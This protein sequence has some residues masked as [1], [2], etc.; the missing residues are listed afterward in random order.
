MTKSSLGRWA[1]IDIETSGIDPSYDT[2][3]DVGFLQFEGTKLVRSYQSLV[4]RE[5]E[6][7]QFIQKLTGISSSILKNAPKWKEV[8][9]EVCELYGH[10]LLAHNSDFEKSFLEK[11]F[12]AIED[13][14]QREIYADSLNFLGLLFPDSESLKLEKFI[15]KWGLADKEIHRGYEDSVDLLKVLIVAK[16]LIEKDKKKKSYLDS[17]ILK[18]QLDEWWYARFF[19]LTDC[20]TLE[21]AET[22]GFDSEEAVKKAFELTS[23]IEEVIDVNISMEH[24]FSGEHVKQALQNEEQIRTILPQYKYRKTQEDLALK[25]GQSFKNNVHSLVQAPTGTGKTMGYLVPS[26]LF[27]LAE[28]KQVLVATGTKTLQQQAMKKDVPIVKKI[29]GLTDND[30]KVTR[31][32]GSNNHYCELMFHDENKDSV[33]LLLPNLDFEQRFAKAFFEM[34]FF[35]NS[36]VEDEEYIIKGALPYV[37]KK[38]NQEL[39]II[40]ENIAVDFR[41]CS[42]H[43]CPFARSCSY[44]NSLKKA[45]DS[46]IIIGNH[47]LMFQWPRGFPRP[48]HI[49][50]DEAHK[51][52]NDAT[53]SF[54]FVFTQ[55]HF[56]HFANS[57][58]NSQGLG[59]LYYLLAQNEESVGTSTETIN[60]LRNESR[61]IYE[62]LKDQIDFLPNLF[63]QFFKAT[64]R[65][66]ELYWNELP[67]I[68]KEAAN[69]NLALS[70]IGALESIQFLLNEL[71]TLFLP[72]HSRF[73]MK[74][75]NI[76]NQI[77]ALT[78]FDFFMG[79]LTD[80]ITAIE[81]S[82]DKSESLIGE[83]SRSLRFHDKFGYELVTAPIDIGRVLHDQLLSTSSSVV[84]TSATLGNML[85]NHGA[86]GI[87]WSTGYLYL[88]PEKRFKS[89]LYLPPVY[90][91]KEKTR[92]F[93][94]DDT[95]ALY[96]HH[97]VETALRPVISLIL[98]L[99]G[100]SLL[101]FSA[102]ARF[103]L[104]REILLKQLEGKLPLFIQGMGENIV[105]EF[106]EAGNGVLLGMETFGE[107][108]DIPGDSLQFVFIDK[109]PDLPMD[110]VIQDRRDYYEKNIG[111]EF[112]D[113]YLAHRT[114]S[115]HQKLGRLLRTEKDHGGVIVVD[116]RIKKWKGKTLGQLKD[117]MN[118][119]E[120][121]RTNLV[122]ACDGVRKFLDIH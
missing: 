8:E 66:S 116:S 72:H 15:V 35:H 55:I 84:F 112:N 94:C 12:D 32:V 74:S 83:Y 113:Y 80:L 77:T 88:G 73:E 25:V 97:F 23:N 36:N 59:S 91:Y 45:K 18:Y 21:I 50:V 79:V 58:L 46:D 81:S 38:K 54:T 102:K 70:I 119:Y 62:M 100:R 7:S 5:G 85:G 40:E 9:N 92:V 118:P 90:D 53:R 117:L 28:D 51:I 115:L 87:E 69:N 114:R 75:L 78:R 56:E 37:L 13:G 2:I 29:L 71:Y 42:G 68:K 105:Q 27:S 39:D 104:A 103:E 122:D 67:M 11:S 89:G 109:I 10:T 61:K 24:G 22:I 52:E 110:K 19:K 111:N 43:K 82:L 26:M 3:I 41:A 47:A 6:L 93:L 14:T 64:P 31:L 98:D 49:V 57:L 63:E 107:G 95:P 106:K 20:E 44:L 120:I 96:D 16:G 108:I 30:I 33:G 121:H 34:V 101:L 76:D 4:Y 99:G 1:V 17:L 65:Y 60:H 86:K 48:S